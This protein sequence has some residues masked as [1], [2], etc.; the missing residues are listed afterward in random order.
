MYIYIFEN[1]TISQQKE[2]HPD[3]RQSLV[4]GYLVIIDISDPD[5]PVGLVPSGEWETIPETS[6]LG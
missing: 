5:K 4:D 2:I 1:G 3:D 6:S